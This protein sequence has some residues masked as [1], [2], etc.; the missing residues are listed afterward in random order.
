MTV[1]HKIKTSGNNRNV[2]YAI[3]SWLHF[4]QILDLIG[5]NVLQLIVARRLRIDGRYF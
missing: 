4:S 5:D 1:R 2:N 3:R